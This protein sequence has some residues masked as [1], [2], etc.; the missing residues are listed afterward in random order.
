M[1]LAGAPSGSQALLLWLV[2]LS[3]KQSPR[4]TVGSKEAG[5]IEQ[6]AFNEIFEAS[7]AQGV[8]LLAAAQSM[9]KPIG[10]QP[11]F[12]GGVVPQSQFL[13]GVNQA[14]KVANRVRVL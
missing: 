5:W 11:Q 2:P 3:F 7:L 8:E 4:I 1:H 10:I 12:R 6:P 9:D 14:L 13:T